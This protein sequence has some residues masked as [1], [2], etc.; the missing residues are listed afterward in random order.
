MS[1]DSV[2][3]K[4]VFGKLSEKF[5]TPVVNLV[6]SGIIGLIAIFLDVATPTSFIN[7]GAFIAFKLVNASVVFH[8]VRQRRAG[9]RLNP[10]T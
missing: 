7:F 8:Y 1:R 4:A 10:V 6:I 5:H 9:H 3:S 2:L